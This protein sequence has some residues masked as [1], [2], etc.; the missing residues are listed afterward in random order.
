MGILNT[1][2]DSFSD[3]GATL[4]PIAAIS[5]G[6]RLVAAGAHIIDIGGEST[7][8][9]AAPIS[10]EEEAGRVL[11]VIRELAAAGYVLSIDTRNASTMASALDA[12]ARIVND[13]S[14]LTHDPAA[15]PLVAARKCPMVLMHMRGTPE[16]MQVRA[17]Y[18]DVVAEVRAELAALVAAACRAGI[19]DR[20]IMLD[21]GIGF[22]KKAE[23][24]IDLLRHL[25]DLAA[26]GFPLLVGVSRKAFIG[27]LSGVEIPRDRLG[28]SIAAA[29][30]AASQGAAILRVHDVVETAQAL[31]VW[32]ALSSARESRLLNL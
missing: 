15:A 21:P 9:G 26:L 8:P 19:L 24:S 6:H 5:A 4:D 25:P 14:G 7:R 20:Q 11:P 12:G 28:G 17:S 27:R 10:P 23:H 1:T 30:F 18:Q 29:I 16:T 13:I 22:A 3:G 2:P 31:K 32:K